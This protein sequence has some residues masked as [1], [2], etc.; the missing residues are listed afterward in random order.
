LTVARTVSRKRRV[1]RLV[2]EVL[3]DWVFREV[4]RMRINGPMTFVEAESVWDLILGEKAAKAYREAKKV[5]FVR[6]DTCE[7]LR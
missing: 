2:S 7:F 1:L 6:V 4:V 5:G 3:D